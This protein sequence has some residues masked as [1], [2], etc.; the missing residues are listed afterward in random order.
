MTS[1]LKHTAA[2]TTLPLLAD[3]LSH[4]QTSLFLIMYG[5][6]PARFTIEELVA[7]SRAAIADVP[8]AAPNP[9]VWSAALRRY[10]VNESYIQHKNG[11]F[12]VVE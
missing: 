7:Q 5:V 6:R 2:L 1:T 12:Q 9:F 3:S 4:T 11:K 8:E 10:V